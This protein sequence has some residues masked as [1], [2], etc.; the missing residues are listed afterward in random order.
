MLKR[1]DVWTARS[2]YIN[3]SSVVAS[4][5][6]TTS[7]ISDPLVSPKKTFY[8]LRNTVSNVNNSVFRSTKRY[9]TC[10]IE[11]FTSTVVTSNSVDD[12]LG[13]STSEAETDADTDADACVGVFR[14]ICQESD[15]RT[16]SG[17]GS[18]NQAE[19][20]MGCDHRTKNGMG[21]DHRTESGM[22]SDNRTEIGVESGAGSE[23]RS[24]E[25]IAGKSNPPRLARFLTTG[26]RL[27]SW[28]VETLDYLK[29]NF[30]L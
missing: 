27:N 16:E 20:G 21:C 11:P 6:S 14:A 13:A 12:T 22:E 2:P 23:S 29:K 3:T 7:F 8:R 9:T 19:S 10:D 25:G 1:N 4:S 17:M 28:L 30:F 18:D 15:H 26:S 24:R 5:A